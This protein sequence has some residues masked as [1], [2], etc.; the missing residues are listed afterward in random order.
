MEAW[1]VFIPP[2]HA[3]HR[4]IVKADMLLFYKVFTTNG[5]LGQYLSHTST[6][7][8][9]LGKQAIRDSF[10]TQIQTLSI[11]AHK[12]GDKSL[13][14]QPERTPFFSLQQ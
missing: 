1:H 10:Q 3:I 2:A 14:L 4:A 6:P 13:L 12:K 8:K 11:V 5:S 7:G 9:D